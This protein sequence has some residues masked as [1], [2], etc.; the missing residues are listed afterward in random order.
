[1]GD[2]SLS[3]GVEVTGFISPTDTSDTYPVTDTLYG[4]D[5]LRNVDNLTQLNAIPNDRRRS[6]ML[7]GVSGGTEYY[8]LNSSPWSGMV[9]DWSVFTLGGD[10][11]GNT[12]GNC[13][14]DLYI[15]NL[16]G[17][18]PITVNNSLQSVTS[19]ATGTTS[20]AFGYNTI[21]SGNGSHAEGEGTVA[22]GSKGAHAEGGLTIASGSGSHAEGIGSIASNDSAH[23]EGFGTIAS[24]NNSHAEGSG[25]ISSGDTCHAEGIDTIAVLTLKVE[26]HSQVENPIT[27]KG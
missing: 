10:F 8:K 19:S 21:A 20:F 26:V 5:G 4:I 24:G 23:A 11:T 7:V 18:S 1:M 27:Q 9:S 13:I 25:T 6:G 16:Y 15:T 12:S 22:S 17:C 3:G 2:F 14:T